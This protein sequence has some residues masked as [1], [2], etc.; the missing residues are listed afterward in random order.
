MLLSAVSLSPRVPCVQRLPPDSKMRVIVALEVNRSM[1]GMSCSG[2]TMVKSPPQPISVPQIL[3]PTQLQLTTPHYNWI[4][5]LPFPRM[6]DNVIFLSKVCDVDELF[7]DFFATRSFSVKEGALAWDPQAWQI[8][9]EFEA[10]WGYL[11]Y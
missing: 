5:P 1:L 2:T 9:P 3:H 8:S 6:R 10:K 4:D 11:F 7:R